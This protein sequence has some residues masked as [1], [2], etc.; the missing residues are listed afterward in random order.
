MENQISPEIKEIR[1]HRLI[2]LSNKNE[3]EYLDALIGKKLDV[4]FEE[5]DNGYL[6]GHT[7][8]YILVKAKRN[9]DDLNRI[10]NVKISK[11]ENDC[12]VS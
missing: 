12:L 11:A 5:E 1:S 3:K 8:N 4:L 10:C 9:T 6:K 2:E 7:Q